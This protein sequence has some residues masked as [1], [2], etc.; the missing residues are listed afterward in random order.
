MM[1]ETELKKGSFGNSTHEYRGIL[2]A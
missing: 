1:D 2:T